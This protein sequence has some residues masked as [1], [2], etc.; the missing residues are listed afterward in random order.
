MY[1]GLVRFFFVGFQKGE[2]G[3][4]RACPAD[5]ISNYLN[6]PIE[7]NLESEMTHKI[8]DESLGVVLHEVLDSMEHVDFQVGSTSID[9]L[10]VSFVVVFLF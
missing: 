2:K 8:V 10:L 4:S 5:C 7:L 1:V 3:G 6:N 9:V